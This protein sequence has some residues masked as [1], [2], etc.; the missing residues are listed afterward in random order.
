LILTVLTFRILLPENCTNKMYNLV[1]NRILNLCIHR[2][3]LL[4]IYLH[5][6]IRRAVK[7]STA[8]QFAAVCKIMG[9]T[10]LV[11][12]KLRLKIQSLDNPVAGSC[13]TIVQQP[14][15]RPGRNNEKSRRIYFEL[16]EL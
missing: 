1:L 7:H 10:H 5:Y 12:Q 13:C 14:F 8:F 2:S 6:T 15:I 11:S 16:G 4:Y 9:T 3:S